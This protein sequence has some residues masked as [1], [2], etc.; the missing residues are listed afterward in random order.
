M[1]SLFVPAELGFA[2]NVQE[3]TTKQNTCGCVLDDGL[4]VFDTCPQTM[5]MDATGE[6][7]SQTKVV[8]QVVVFI[9]FADEG[10][11][12]YEKRGGMEYLLKQFEGTAS[13]MD[14][15]I[16]EYSWGQVDSNVYFWP[17][18]SDGTPVCYVDEHPV[19]YYKEQTSSNP[20]GYTSSNEY[21]RRTTLLNNAI[22]FMGTNFQEK[23]GIEDQPYNLVFV[24]PDEEGW[25][26]LL[27][28]HKS[29]ISVNGKWN[30][31]NFITY[32]QKKNMT[33]VLTHEFM[34]S[35]GYP[36]MYHYPD[37]GKGDAP[38]SLGIWSMMDDAYNGGHPTVHEKYRYS[39]W[40]TNE[41]AIQTISKSGHYVLGPATEHPDSNVLAYKIP[42]NGMTDKYF[43]IEYRGNENAGFDADLRNEGLIFYR[44]D[45][46]QE[47][48]DNGPPDEVFVLREGDGDV[49]DAYYDGTTGR[50]SFSEFEFYNDTKD[51]GINVYNIKKENGCMSFDISLAATEFYVSKNSPASITDTI[52][53]TAAMAGNGYEYR[54]GTIYNGKEIEFNNGYTRSSTC[55]VVLSA[56][57]GEG[58]GMAVG[59]HTLFVDIKDTE[60]GKVMRRTIKDYV[61]EGLEITSFKADKVSPRKVGTSIE[62][63]VQVE[64]EGYYRYNTYKFTV[65]KNGVETNLST[66]GTAKYNV[67]WKPTEA[68]TYTLKYYIKDYLGQEATAQMQY[69]VYSENTALVYY[70]N[71]SW[72]NANIHYKVGNGVWTTAPGVIM[73]DSNIEGYTWCYAIDL[74]TAVSAT[75]CFNNG[76]NTWDSNGG[77]NYTVKKGLNGIGGEDLTFSLK[78]IT[79]TPT[80]SAPF[81]TIQLSGGIAPY[82][83]SYEFVDKTTNEVVSSEKNCVTYST[84]FTSP[85]GP[86]ITGK[87]AMNIT[88]T[89]TLGQTVTASKD[90]ILEPFTISD[91]TASA[92]SPQLPNTEITLNVHY[93]NAF[94]YKY[95]LIANWTITNKTTNATEKFVSYYTRELQWTP[96]EVGEYEITVSAKDN[97]AESAM[98]TINYSVV[99]EVKNEATVYYYNS[100]WTNAYI[101]YRVGN[102]SWT[103]VP[104]VKMATGTEQSGY[105]WKYVI[106]LKDADLATVC[107]NNGSGSWDSDNGKN[108]TVSAGISGIKSGTVNKLTPVLTVTPTITPTVTLTITPTVTPTVTPTI[109]PTVTPTI[110]PTAT[111]TVTPTSTPT[112]TPIPVVTKTTVYYSNSSWTQ[113][114]IHYRV[115]NGNWTTAPGVKMD[116]NT[117]GNGYTWKY[118]ID[119]GSA[120]NTTVCFNNGNGSWDS[121]NGSNYI[122]KSGSYGIKNQRTEQLPEGLNVSLD[123]YGTRGSSSARATVAGG[124]APYTYSY[125]ITRDGEK[126]QEAS[127]TSTLDYY[128]YTV[129]SYDGGTYKVD[130]VVT[131][132][133]GKTGTA[134][135]TEYF[136]PLN[137]ASI[138]SSVA[139]P[140]KTGTTVTFVADIQSEYY[141]KFPNYRSWSI[142]KNG[143]SYGGDSSYSSEITYTFEEEGTYEITCSLRDASGQTATK[144]VQF[145]VSDAT[146]VATIYYNTT[147][148]NAY[149]H[150][151]IAG[152][153]W[154]AVP[155]VAMIK[156]SEKAGYTHKYVIDLDKATNVVAC[157]NNGSGSWDSRNGSNYTIS[158]GTYGVKNGSVSKL[159]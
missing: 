29:S 63:S 137:I 139:S 153:S 33:R 151:C 35:L 99:D 21:S 58:N 76:N 47:G 4:T 120:D 46:T 89:D 44:V 40:I 15:Y 41:N 148:S 155:G 8:N 132:A 131:D 52:E 95:G 10:K 79:G 156:T 14:R 110:T 125:V 39:D 43:M 1:V 70:K 57:L 97:N 102:G 147:W 126:T 96:T 124:V 92:N 107:F 123:L 6:E 129:T 144:T 71:A 135:D 25:R 121:K 103:S 81:Y 53:L 12:I 91:I 94:I 68:G 61:V 159:Q 50:T 142:T 143:V 84:Y 24:V 19:A 62:L 83:Y 128:T 54:F 104:G 36:D 51:Y 93:E 115:G 49:D 18:A 119:L 31:Y 117:S 158:A 30:T 59:N 45:T 75:V 140:Q 55:S 26:D 87:Y 101:H 74:G 38:T 28:S 90:Y 108:Y 105:K 122:L 2:A 136:A 78:S 73:G 64:N 112:V 67:T 146:N 3:D 116:A 65:E 138:T 37:S 98:Y 56:I 130:V 5:T 149:I 27:W 72:Q 106:D 111:P 133:E 118:V 114:Y 80:K 113:A 66:S 42:I 85:Y 9:A 16:D 134:T 34:H 20:D 157:F 13:S 60:T 11:D 86:R 154:T 22:E 145:V 17:Q 150:Y 82:T 100:S 127:H 23:L 88:V 48:N 77:K 32:P 152:K 7:A 69:T 109:T 141:Y